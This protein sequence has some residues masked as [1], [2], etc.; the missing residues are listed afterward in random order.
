MKMIEQHQHDVDERRHV[1]LVRLVEVVAAARPALEA[2]GHRRYSA[3]RAK[4]PGA[5][6]PWS[7]SR[8]TSRS[9]AAAAS[10]SRAR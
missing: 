8:L 9:T 6:R 3:A 2:A 7:R 5:S 4:A 10:A 1:D